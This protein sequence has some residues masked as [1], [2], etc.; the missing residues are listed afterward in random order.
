MRGE[1]G[2]SIER[3]KTGKPPGARVGDVNDIGD[4]LAEVLFRREKITGAGPE[5]LCLPTQNGP[6][7]L[8]GSVGIGAE[9]TTMTRP[10]QH[11]GS[12]Y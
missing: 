8:K 4:T 3:E 6:N 2:L 9:G 10:P 12:R 5:P 7:R 1:D 11:D